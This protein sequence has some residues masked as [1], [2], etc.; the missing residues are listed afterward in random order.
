LLSKNNWFIKW[1]VYMRCTLYSQQF[2]KSKMPP[3]INEVRV[4]SIRMFDGH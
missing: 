3:S 1:D 2:Y 4:K